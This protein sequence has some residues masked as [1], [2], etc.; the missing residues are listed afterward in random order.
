MPPKLLTSLNS[1]GDYAHNCAYLLDHATMCIH[2]IKIVR[3]SPFDYP[4]YQLQGWE[5][6]LPGVS[7][8]LHNIEANAHTTGLKIIGNT[9][10]CNLAYVCSYIYIY[11]ILYA[12]TYLLMCSCIYV[13]IY[14][15]FSIVNNE[16]PNQPTTL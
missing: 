10:E 8:R 5:T 4:L 7:A 3:T 14:V 2:T 13:W 11:I 9:I 6:T 12:Y 15:S 16:Q 1:Q